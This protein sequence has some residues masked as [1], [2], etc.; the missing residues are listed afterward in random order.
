MEFKRLIEKAKKQL[1]DD[2]KLFS[3]DFEQ[4]CTF[5]GYKLDD[6]TGRW[7]E[8]DDVAPSLPIGTNNPATCG[9]EWRTY[10]GFSFDYQYCIKCDLKKPVPE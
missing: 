3:I 2:K 1:D 8:T 7:V 9:H 5:M 10:A 6:I 4:F